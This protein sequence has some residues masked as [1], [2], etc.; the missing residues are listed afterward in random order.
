VTASTPDPPDGWVVRD[1]EGWP[2]GTLR[3]GAAELVQRHLITSRADGRAGMLEA[4]AFLHSV[5]ITGWNDALLGGYAAIDDPTRAYLDLVHD[6]MLTARVRGSL[7]WDRHR[8]PEQVTEL[9]GRRD[10]L[11]ARGLDAGAVKMMADGIAETLTASMLEPYRHAEGCPCG[12]QGLPFMDDGA[13]REAVVA[14]DAAGLQVHFHAIGDRAVRAVLDA[15]QAARSLH[16]ANDLRHHV[17]HLQVV[18][19]DDRP[20]FGALGVNATVQGLWADGSD[21]AAQL[22]RPYLGDQRWSEQYPFADIV[23]HGAALAGGSDWPVD[24]PHPMLAVHALVNRRGYDP[25]HPDGERLAPEQALDLH[26][27]MAGYTSG[28]ARVNH[29]DDSGRLVPG[30]RADIAVLDRDPFLEP[31]DQIGAAQAIRTYV[32]GHCVYE[33]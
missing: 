17:A 1:A 18:H 24:V 30:A 16:G 3:E 5:G 19:P 6:G 31:V 33:A 27:A 2:T 7:W 9:V 13:L 4:Q 11:R 21:P 20:R 10:A 14:C 26:T 28:S 32:G 12:D 15:V 23:R 8:G 25:S 29:H 22:V